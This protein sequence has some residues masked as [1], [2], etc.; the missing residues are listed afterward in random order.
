MMG[1]NWLTGAGTKGSKRGLM[2]AAKTDKTHGVVFAVG[3]DTK[4]GVQA[5]MVGVED[6]QK[7]ALIAGA[8]KGRK[9]VVVTA[10][11]DR[12]KD[13]GMYFIM[14]KNGDKGKLVTMDYKPCKDRQKI[15]SP[16]TKRCMSVA[17]VQKKIEEYQHMTPGQ[18]K[19]LKAHIKSKMN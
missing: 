7:R 10:M 19:K 1:K 11:E 16:M 17:T 14:A 12:N 5:G 13:T 18:R 9:R 8:K 4:T 2:T 3:K 15:R 6:G